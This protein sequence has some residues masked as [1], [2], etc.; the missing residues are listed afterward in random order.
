MNTAIR[1]VESQEL[2]EIVSRIWDRDYTLWSDSPDEITNRLGWLDVAD[3]MKSEVAN[4]DDFARQ[5]R[6]EGIRHVALLGMGGSSLGAEVLNQCLGAREGW[7]E[8]IV[9]DSTLPAQI[10]R[11]VDSIDL[12]RTLFVVSSKSGTTTEPR[13]LYEFFREKLDKLGC[14][15]ERFVAITDPGTPLAEIGK[16]EGFRKTFLNPPDICGRFS[17]LSYFGLVPAALAGYDVAE[18]L[19]SAVMMSDACGPRIP[20]HDNPGATMGASFAS[21]AASGRDKLTILT[22]PGLDSFGLWAEQ[23]LAESLGKC[24]KGIVPVTDEPMADVAYYS[25]DRQFVYLKLSGDDTAT[26]CLASDLARAGHPLV[27]Y[28]LEDMSALGGEFFRWEFAVATAAALIGVN[29]FDQP[30]VERAKV[31]TA[32]A[33]ESTESH[34]L[35]RQPLRAIR[36]QNS[37]QA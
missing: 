16:G 10:A 5:V 27:Q 28:E 8:L 24:G 23:L 32:Q 22:S 13:L 34:K 29:P 20:A 33:L 18:I 17:V 15:G 9:L 12:E 14:G 36:S 31:L 37:F 30:D 4:L 26:D 19:D 3:S 35:L 1:P 7:P 11:T 25:R 2:N 21:L 6:D